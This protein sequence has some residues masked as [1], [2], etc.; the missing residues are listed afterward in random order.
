[1]ENPEKILFA[2][3]KILNKL[4][5]DMKKFLQEGGTGKNSLHI[6]QL[7]RKLFV[8]EKFHPGPSKKKIIE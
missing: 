1:M 2:N 7:R 3:P 8:L 5:A 4:F 6:Q